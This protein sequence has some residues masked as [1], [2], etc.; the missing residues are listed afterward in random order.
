MRGHSAARS[1]D[2]VHLAVD[3]D[4]VHL[5]DSTTGDRLVDATRG[6]HTD[7]FGLARPH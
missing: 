6:V 3:R 1:G 2:T 4:H 5:F 7:A